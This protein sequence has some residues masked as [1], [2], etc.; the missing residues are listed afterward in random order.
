VNITGLF[1]AAVT[2]FDGAGAVDVQSLLRH[3]GDIVSTDGVAGVAIL[4]H[5]GEITT[6]A[7]EER[8]SVV[9]AARTAVPPDKLLVAG[10]EARTAD[11]VAREAEQA[12]RAGADALLVLP[13]F[14]V[15]PLRH[16]ARNAEAVHGFFEALDQRLGVPM[17]VFHYPPATGC[18]YSLDALEAIADIPSVRAIK[19]SAGDI[20]LYTEI[21][22]RLHGRV[23]ILAAADSP[24]ILPMLVHGADGAVLGVSAVGTSIWADLVADCAAGDF[25]AAASLF[26]QRCLPLTTAIYENQLQRSGIASFAATKEALVQLGTI[27]DATVRPPA[28]GPDDRRKKEIASALITA[29]LQPPR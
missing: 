11:Q 17:I 21:Y 7:P 20:T 23:S 18:S 28:I 2:P 26:K 13:P 14:D 3:V 27:A 8:R 6:L 29:G 16:L 1:P 9:A 24:L 5:A 12:V 19:A 22:D 15:R 10:V 4:G 25:T